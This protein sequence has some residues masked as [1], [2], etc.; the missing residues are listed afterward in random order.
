MIKVFRICTGE[1]LIS[2]VSQETAEYYSLSYPAL[3]KNN[4]LH[5]YMPEAG[6]KCDL[7]KPCIISV[8]LADPNLVHVYNSMF[9]PQGSSDLSCTK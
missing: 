5:M 1:T 9:G 8:G 3:L 2:L 6:G 4:S 7:L